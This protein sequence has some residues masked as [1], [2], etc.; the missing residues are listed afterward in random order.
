M[1]LVRHAGHRRHCRRRNDY[2]DHTHERSCHSQHNND[3]TLG[4]WTSSSRQRNPQQTFIKEIFR[5]ALNLGLSFFVNHNLGHLIAYSSLSKPLLNQTN[6]NSINKRVVVYRITIFSNPH[7]HLPETP[8][9]TFF[10]FSLAFVAETV[11][12]DRSSMQ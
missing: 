4:S 7:S 3:H 9:T 6:I 10:Q 5:R 8:L 12:F 1:G 2:H 11:Y